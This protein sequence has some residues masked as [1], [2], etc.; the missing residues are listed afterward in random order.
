MGIDRIGSHD[1]SNLL[2]N[3]KD[4]HSIG[5]N[6]PAD[7]KISISKNKNPATISENTS[8]KDLIF[9]ELKRRLAISKAGYIPVTVKE[10]QI[11]GGVAKNDGLGTV[12]DCPKWK[13]SLSK[14]LNFSKSSNLT[15]LLSVLVGWGDALFKIIAHILPPINLISKLI[16]G[17]NVHLSQS[18]VPGLKEL[19][20]CEVINSQKEIA[21]SDVQS[22]KRQEIQ[23]ASMVLSALKDDINK[24]RFGEIGKD[25]AVLIGGTATLDSLPKE[26]REK[27]A[28]LMSKLGEGG[29]EI[30]DDGVIRQK[31][32]DDGNHGPFEA[33]L[34]YDNETK[35]VFL[36]FRG[37]SGGERIE[38]VLSDAM[39]HFGL[40][41]NLYKSAILLT[42]MA[43]QCFGDKNLI[44]SGHSLG[45]GMAQLAAAVSGLPG[46]VVNPAPVNKTLWAR[47]RLTNDDLRN[48][49]QRIFQLS[50]K[51]DVLSDVAFSNSP[52]SKVAQIGTKVV[53]DYSNEEDRKNAFIN[54]ASSTAFDCLQ[55]NIK[56]LEAA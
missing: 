34:A 33:M 22:E 24:N 46:I 25:R 43:K 15:R 26:V 18:V 50:V 38:T 30:C 32:R 10:R 3:I 2:S 12:N 39:Q 6:T 14:D 52:E 41:D 16:T 42:D 17:E 8:S 40:T 13:T 55:E 54:H 48:A 23:F 31:D 28:L 47:T 9:S 5:K 11:A 4:S 7:S 1:N 29:F 21:L 19:N 35:N 27:T 49:S 53:I 37:T 20:S 36:A 44:I 45:G 51:N 56:E